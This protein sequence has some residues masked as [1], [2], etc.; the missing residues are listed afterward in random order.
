[1]LLRII[2]FPKKKF[3]PKHK[4]NEI[5]ETRENIKLFNKDIAEILTRT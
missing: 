3:P 2:V 5:L 1:M 4:I